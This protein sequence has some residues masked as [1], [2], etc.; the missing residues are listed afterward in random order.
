MTITGSRSVRGAGVSRRL[1]DGGAQ[2][3]HA[4]PVLH[5]NVFMSTSAFLLFLFQ[6][7]FIINFFYSIF[8]GRRV[9]SN[10]WQATT[11]E[12][13][14]TTSPPLA[15]GNFAVAP[16]V[17]RGPY[18]YSVPGHPTD[19][20]PQHEPEDAAPAPV[21]GGG[22]KGLPYETI[23][24]WTGVD[25]LDRLDNQHAVVLRRGEGGALNLEAIAL[26]CFEFS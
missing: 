5:T 17:Y 9:G 26:P 12:W 18:E 16:V 14:A 8:K 13:A 15:H 3:E 11:L 22:K 19:F 25:H 24:C 7:P 23:V 10:L 1:Y 20:F 21:T 6:L 2:Y 4:K